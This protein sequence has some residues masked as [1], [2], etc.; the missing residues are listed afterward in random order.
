VE[1]ASSCPFLA[2]GR[3][4]ARLRYS[5]LVLLPIALAGLSAGGLLGI[6]TAFK[7]AGAAVVILVLMGF[8]FR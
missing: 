5:G 1:S 6:L 2:T 3:R 8:F 4:L 7:L